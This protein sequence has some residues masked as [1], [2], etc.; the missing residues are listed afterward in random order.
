MTEQIEKKTVT[1][2]CKQRIIATVNGQLPGPT[3]HVSDGD[4]VNIKAYNRAGYNA[5]LHWYVSAT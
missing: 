5:T 3:I 2:L 1:R 4:T